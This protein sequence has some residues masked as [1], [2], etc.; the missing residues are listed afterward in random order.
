MDQSPYFNVSRRSSVALCRNSI[1]GGMSDMIDINVE[2]MEYLIVLDYL[3]AR[4]LMFSLR[5]NK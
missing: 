2:K 4:W 5:N 1:S 3:Q